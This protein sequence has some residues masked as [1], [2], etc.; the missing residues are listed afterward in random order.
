[1]TAPESNRP[2]TCAGCIHSRR[3]FKTARPKAWCSKYKQLRDSSCID[4]KTRPA[5]IKAAL[6]FWRV[7]L[8]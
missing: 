8:K 4:Y 3:R 2:A 7:S 5:A 1:M 6:N